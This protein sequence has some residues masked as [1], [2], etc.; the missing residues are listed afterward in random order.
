MKC[1]LSSMKP[2]WNEATTKCFVKSDGLWFQLNDVAKLLL[3]LLNAISLEGSIVYV[4]CTCST[5]CTIIE[6]FWIFV[7]GLRITLRFPLLS[8]RIEI[9]PKKG[10]T[11]QLSNCCVLDWN[12]FALRIVDKGLVMRRLSLTA[13]FD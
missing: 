10:A 6:N 11:K 4:Y 13:H 2:F 9:R 3:L 8:V 12:F 1:L 5:M 7:V